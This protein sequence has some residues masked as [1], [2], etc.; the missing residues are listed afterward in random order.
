MVVVASDVETSGV[1][2]AV[3]RA[4][5]LMC[6]SENIDLSVWGDE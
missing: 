5:V 4:E 3:C 1:L 6:R 2:D